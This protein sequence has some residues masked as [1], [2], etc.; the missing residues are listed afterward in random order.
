MSTSSS[1]TLRFNAPPQSNAPSPVE[2]I[3]IPPENL[4]EDRAQ[5]LYQ[6]LKNNPEYLVLRER[7]LPWM[8]GNSFSNLTFTDTTSVSSHVNRF[9]ILELVYQHLYA[10]GMYNTAETLQEESHLKFQKSSQSWDQTTIMLLVS[11]GVLP[12]EDPW[13]IQPDPHNHFFDEYLEE[14]FFASPYRDPNMN[15]ILKELTDANYKSIYADSANNI[16]TLNTLKKGSMN[17]LV[18]LVTTTGDQHALQDMTRF[19]LSLHAITSSEHFLEHLITL[20]DLNYK[21]D[22]DMPDRQQLRLMIVN[23]IKK[24]VNEHGK[25]I[26]NKTI[27]EIGKFL[28]RVNEDPSCQNISKFTQNVL[29]YLPDIQFGPKNQPT[30]NFAEKPVIPDYHILFQ[31]NLTILD[32]DPI[33]VARQITLL[34]HK[35]FKLVHSREFITALRIQGV[36]H[37]TPTLVDFFDF[38]KKLTLLVIETIM[39]ASDLGVAIIN[40]LQIADALDKLNNFHALACIIIALKQSRIKSHPVMQNS[41]NKEK[42]EYLFGRSGNNPKKINQYSTAIKELFDQSLP[43]IP[44]LM[45]EFNVIP[46]SKPGT[47]LN[48][49]T[50]ESDSSPIIDKDGLI[51]WEIIWANSYKTLVFYWFQFKCR[52][53]PYYD[54]RQIQ[55]VINKGPLD[56][57]EVLKLDDDSFTMLNL[58]NKSSHRQNNFHYN[59]L[60]N[61]TKRKDGNDLIIDRRIS[62][63]SYS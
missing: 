28:K 31:P 43:A 32:P 61:R 44:N 56:H 53:Y 45:A 35:A 4:A 34:F 2:E 41:S 62:A 16:K 27:K 42:F 49:Y 11:L 10:I 55:D 63:S 57:D 52:P 60:N 22:K 7:V 25:F 51:N 1:T 3:V 13:E 40:T 20:F 23:L 36:S 30:L 47:D 18:V 48:S 59:G 50:I 39:N 29:S 58:Q 33:E 15:E 5:Y 38:G 46:K 19:F 54:I 24:W 14:D 37:Q 8:G 17:R 26:G 12:N 6:I 21:P 9:R